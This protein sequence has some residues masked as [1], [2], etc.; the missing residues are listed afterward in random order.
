M[1]LMPIFTS[2]IFLFFLM[3]PVQTNAQESIKETEQ[4]D[5]AQ[6]LLTRGMYD[7][8]I[9]QC[10]KFISDYPHSASLQDAYLSLGEGYFLSQDFNKAV[11]TFNQFKQLYPNSD[12]LPVSL[13]RLAQIDIQQKKYDE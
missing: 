13:L 6:G 2:I 8:A 12:R 1:N 7:M 3:G 11:D 10:Q 4:L 9:T 5:F